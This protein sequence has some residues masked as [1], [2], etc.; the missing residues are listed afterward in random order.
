MCINMNNAITVVILKKAYKSMSYPSK[1]EQH[2]L[3]LQTYLSRE[4]YNLSLLMAQEY[5]NNVSGKSHALWRREEVT[6]L[7]VSY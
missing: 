1:K 6:N 5:F 7:N 3:N 2:I 4:I